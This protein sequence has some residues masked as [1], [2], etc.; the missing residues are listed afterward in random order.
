MD[1]EQH[2]RHSVAA[3]RSRHPLPTCARAMGPPRS[4][5]KSRTV[6]AVRAKNA[7]ICASHAG[8]DVRSTRPGTSVSQSGKPPKFHSAHTYGPKRRF[9]K[10]PWLARAREGGGLGREG[11]GARPGASASRLGLDEEGRQVVVVTQGT[12]KVPLVGLVLQGER[13]GEDMSP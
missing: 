2:R 10:R 13:G 1:A 8:A 3:A 4:A 11:R 6:S 9:T 7:P 5:K 12:G